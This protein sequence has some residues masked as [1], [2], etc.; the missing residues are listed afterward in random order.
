MKVKINDTEIT[1][2]DG[3]NI[4]TALASQ[5]IEPK[6]IAI[7]LNGTVIPKGL[8]DSTNLSNGDTIIIIK[9]FY[10]G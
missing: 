2:Q 9:A 7:A 3:A 6:G 8:Y 1:L 4:A 10:G 5:S